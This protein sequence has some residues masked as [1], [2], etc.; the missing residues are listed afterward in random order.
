MGK[1]SVPLS[2]SY[3]NGLNGYQRVDIYELNPKLECRKIEVSDT[4]KL[5]WFLSFWSRKFFL[6][7]TL[8]VRTISSY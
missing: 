3:S 8:S 4:R 2:P 5:V 7:L 1:M 6:L